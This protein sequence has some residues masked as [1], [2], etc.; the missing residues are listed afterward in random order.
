MATEPEA[1]DEVAEASVAARRGVGRDV[2]VTFGGRI[3]LTGVILIGDIIIA[4]TL[5]PEGKGAFTLVLALS[6]LGA[7]ILGLG[8]D[9]SVAVLGARSLQVARLAF[10]N[11][12]VWT[13]AIGTLGVAAIV[14][15]YGAPADTPGDPG[16]LAALMPRLT[17]LQLWLAALSLPAEI[18]YAI[19][20]MALLGGQLVVSFNVLRFLR[21][22]L[23]LPLLIGAALLRSLDLTMLLVLN[24][25]VVSVITLGI[26]WAMA[27]AGRIGWRTDGRLLVEQLSFG[28]RAFI[29]TIA[30]RLHYRANTFLLTGL[31]S[32][33]ATG[34]FSVA[35]GLAE[36]LW[37]LPS[38]FGLVLFSRAVGAGADSARIASAMT[39]T[40]LALGVVIAIPLW[41][42]APTLV[43][44]VYGSPFREAGAALQVMLPGV[45]AYSV[46]A[47]LTHFI[48]AW[49]APGRIAAVAIIGLAINLVTCLALIPVL[50]MTGAAL[51][52]SISY[53]AS[54]ALTLL[55]FRR[56]SGQGLLE[57]LVVSRSDIAARWREMRAIVSR[58][59]RRVT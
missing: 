30:E 37:Y 39:R 40:V 43:E 23:L 8:L 54:A 5:G 55:L 48:V 34:V 22:G 42:L 44:L 4:R 21:R 41:F 29:G 12:A 3:A 31:V 11:A 33:A 10:G 49:G 20:T 9:R 36:T 56:I 59:E 50:G 25:A 46:V 18:A 17:G 13:V 15:L 16:P 24:L 14:L 57:T 7:L 58:A 6:S 51:A 19:G 1:I 52:S 47:V 32:I 28:G 53:T 27:R 45:V 26:V 2:L 35:L 38:A